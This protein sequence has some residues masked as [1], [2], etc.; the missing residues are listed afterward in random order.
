MADNSINTNP[1][2]ALGLRNLSA[3]NTALEAARNRVATGLQVA[4][5]LN[6]AS[7]FVIGQGTRGEIGSFAAVQQG[8][9]NGRGIAQVATAGA[10]QVSNLL[11]D[12]RARAIQ[13]A[14]P[15]NTASQQS[16]LEQDFRELAGQLRNFIDN[17][18]FNGRN[19]LQAGASDANVIADTEGGTLT[20]RAQD[21]ETSVA[22]ALDAVSLATP[23]DAANALSTIDS[24]TES[25]SRALGQLGAD[26]RALSE[27]DRFTTVISDALEEGLGA[28]VDADLAAQATLFRA[29]EVK[30]ALGVQTLSIANA[31]P[32]LLLSLA[33]AP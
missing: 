9:S 30:Q 17:A 21:L 19:L 5:A 12:I 7:A 27:Q 6:D 14:N 31:Q 33:P 8:L 26:A 22:D 11:T 18:S 28:V 29:Q 23:G 13:A 3:T 1:N 2:A 15:A 25:V 32:N 16:I 20:L 24:A 10:T 4:S